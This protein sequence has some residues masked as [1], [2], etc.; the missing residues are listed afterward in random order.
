MIKFRQQRKRSSRAL[1]DL[2]FLA[3]FLMVFIP[4]MLLTLFI[5]LGFVFF[6]IFL[7]GV[8]DV[9][10]LSKER[11]ARFFQTGKSRLRANILA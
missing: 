7:K 11:F 10:R 2:C 6:E 5:V 1:W 9:V 4:F 8:R 3:F